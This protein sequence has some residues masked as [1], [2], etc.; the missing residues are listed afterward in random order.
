MLEDEPTTGA[1]NSTLEEKRTL[2][3]SSLQFN[4]GNL[5]VC[6][7]LYCWLCMTCLPHPA[8]QSL[9]I[10][11]KYSLRCQLLLNSGSS[12]P[13]STRGYRWQCPV[14]LSRDILSHQCPITSFMRLTHHNILSWGDGAQFRRNFPALVEECSQKAEQV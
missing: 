6:A 11:Q 3:A 2:A 7:R 14:R 12:D 1:V 8:T 13:L 5:Q 9:P 4:C 10:P